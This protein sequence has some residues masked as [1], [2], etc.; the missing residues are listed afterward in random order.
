MAGNLDQSVFVVLAVVAV[1]YVLA[2][3][4]MSIKL[5]PKEPPMVAPKIPYVGHIL[6]LI[7]HGSHYYSRIRFDIPI[8]KFGIGFD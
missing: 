5:D 7:Q 3:R 6:G 2:E 4:F 1:L 8:G